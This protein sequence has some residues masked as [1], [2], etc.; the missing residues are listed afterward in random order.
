MTLYNATTQTHPIT[1]GDSLVT[2]AASN[3]WQDL[4]L[5]FTANAGQQVS[6]GVN[7]NTIA[8]FVSLLG[9]K[10]DFQKFSA[11]A[12]Y[13]LEAL[14]LVRRAYVE[15]MC[16]HYTLGILIMRASLEALIRGA[17]WEGMAHKRFRESA[18]E[19]RRAKGVRIAGQVKRLRDWFEDVLKHTPQAE[20]AF[21]AM[22][23]RCLTARRHS[24]QSET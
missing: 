22:S 13:H 24:S 6:L 19:I 20:D 17:F 16:C 15:T 12:I 2:A 18:K 8:V 3:P 23:A 7:G 11:F 5:T 9:P 1:I 4:K 14:H 10:S 21:E